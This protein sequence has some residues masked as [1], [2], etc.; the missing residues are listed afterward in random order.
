[1]MMIGNGGWMIDGVFV[2]SVFYYAY[3]FNSDLSKW[4]TSRVKNMDYGKFVFPILC[5]I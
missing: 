2:L 1:M 4:S 5:C 3:E